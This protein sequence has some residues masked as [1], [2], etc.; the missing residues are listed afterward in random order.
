MLTWKQSVINAAADMLNSNE[1]T[2]TIEAANH[3][4]H[5]AFINHNQSLQKAAQS[6]A[7]TIKQD[8]E[9]EYQFFKSHPELNP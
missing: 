9:A 8:R 2:T 4:N 6:L 7:F 3:P 5:E 1:C